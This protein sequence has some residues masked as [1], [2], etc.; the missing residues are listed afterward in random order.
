MRNNLY[1]TAP[2][3][4]VFGMAAF[5]MPYA[6]AQGESCERT[7]RDVKVKIK[8][9]D[10]KASAVMKGKK[11]CDTLPVRP[12]DTIEWKLNGKNFE[13]SFPDNTPFDFNTEKSRGHKI[14]ATVRMDAESDSYKYSI[15]IDGGEPWDPRVVVE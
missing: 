4:L 10:N 13:I 12:G 8:V 7:E 11:N 5:L 9:K 6:T 2:V 15:T 1:R 14:E 3:L